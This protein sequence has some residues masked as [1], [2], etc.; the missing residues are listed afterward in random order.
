MPGGAATSP[1]VK[2]AK[3]AFSQPSTNLSSESRLNFKIGQAVFRKIWPLPHIAGSP[4]AGL[5]PLYNARSCEDCHLRDGRGH[6]PEPGK[7]SGGAVSILLKFSVPPQTPAQRE[8]LASY[9]LAAIPDPAYGGQLQDVAVK[10]LTAEGL[11]QV[12]YE[13]IPVVLAGGERITLRNPSYSIGEPGYGPLHANVMMSVR[14]APQMIGLGLL[15]AV[16]EIAIL[17][18]A[19]PDDADGDNISGRVNRVW[20]RE[21]KKV[22]LGRFGWKAGAPT[23]L[24]QSAQA[25]AADMGL[26]SWLVPEP[27]GD[28]TEAQKLCRELAKEPDQNDGE[29]NRDLL[30]SLALYARNLA[31]P[32]RRRANDDQ[33]IAGKQHFSALG[34]AR[35]HNPSFK[36]GAYPKEPHLAHQQIWPYTDL[37]LHDMGEGLADNRPESAAGGR[38]WRTPPLWGIGLTQ[39]VTGRL[40]FLHDGRARTIAEAILWHGGEAQSARDGFAALSRAERESLIAFV[41]SL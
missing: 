4:S 25:F 1:T 7:I 29:V 28:C 14:A 2:D 26:S 9:H 23:V 36:T 18:L 10:G 31:V 15:E 35:C 21:K 33:I 3:K 27:A 39:G 6:P 32:K 16:P 22:V 40:S 19:D 37:L 38:E 41:N 34:C 12:T 5:G 24:Q 13:D 8:Q 17:G 11:L 20:S 30:E